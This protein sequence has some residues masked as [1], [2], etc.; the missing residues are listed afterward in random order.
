M[1]QAECPMSASLRNS[2]AVRFLLT[3]AIITFVVMG[4]GTLISFTITNR[5]ITAS[6]K[7]QLQRQVEG[8][9]QHMEMWLESERVQISAL[10]REKTFWQSLGSDQE[11]GEA[12][13]L[14]ESRLSWLGLSFAYFSSVNLFDAAGE[15]VVSDLLEEELPLL[16]VKQPLIQ[17]ALAGELVVTP[18]FKSQHNDRYVFAIYSAV[19]HQGDTNGVLYFEY[20][21]VAISDLFFKELKT[22]RE[23]YTFVIDS[24]N[25]VI[26]QPDEKVISSNELATQFG[27][28]TQIKE[29]FLKYVNG[30]SEMFAYAGTIDFLDCSLL[31]NIP[32]SEILEPAR[33]LG[34]VNLLNT[35]VTLVLI[36]CMI[37]LLWRKE[38]ATPIAEITRGI[39]EFH[40]GRLEFPV[41]T[42]FR[43]EFKTVAESFNSMAVDI[44]ESTVSIELLKQE[45]R[46]QQIILDSM[47]IGILIVDQN[48]NAMMI[49]SSLLRIL[50][51]EDEKIDIRTLFEQ[52]REGSQIFRDLKTN[53]HQELEFINEQGIEYSLLRVVQSISLSRVE[54]FL[55]MFV[56]ITSQKAA[57]KEQKQLEQDIQAA[58][59]LKAIGTLAAGVSHEINTPIQYV[60]D[61]VRFLSEAMADLMAVVETYKA[62]FKDC[63]ERGRCS[64]K[65]S[66]IETKEDEVDLEFLREE[67]PLSLQ[68]TLGGL[69]NVARIVLAMK[70]FSHQGDET[71][72]PLDVN[73]AIEN[74]L[75]L[76]KNEWKLLARVEYIAG[77]NIP[78][79]NCF[80]GE[81][82]Q[83][84]LNLIVNAAHAIEAKG[85]EQPLETERITIKTFVD[86]GYV[87]ITVS[88]TGIGMT[89][90][91]KARIFEH[92]FT[93]KEVGRGTGQ[94]LTLSYQVVVEKHKGQLLVESSPGNGSTF[95]VKLPL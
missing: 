40:N 27:D 89:E 59:R 90:D 71:M 68:Q 50:G 77:K 83:V 78:E 28:A 80:A 84:V 39:D 15:I 95:T 19:T 48:E 33:E 7:I 14:V 94:G 86:Q 9:I 38:I 67:I 70:T 35:V 63:K 61:N 82:N 79:P 43:N 22:G 16:Q 13:Q 42:Q 87:C 34:K 23:G 30:S 93:T 24:S 81:I 62:E 57:E 20:D 53:K 41:S 10:G 4:I 60:G 44:E 74:T 49:N 1:L 58:G 47:I 37:T 21:L 25:D 11:P 51:R 45:Q 66:A 36:V 8:A 88:D 26:I 64:A 52:T 55:T 32:Y 92:F 2:L 6:T 91:I 65:I 54:V 18:V 17:R 29:R 31:L 72:A 5:T 76:S 85:L 73:M 46:N 69:D 75:I 56:D 12:R 3:I